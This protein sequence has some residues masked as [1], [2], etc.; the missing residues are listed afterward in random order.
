MPKA[1]L[2]ET[3]EADSPHVVALRSTL[4]AVLISPHWSEPVTK[5]GLDGAKYDL[6]RAEQILDRVEQSPAVRAVGASVLN[7]LEAKMV[8]DTM[9]NF[10]GD[11]EAKF[12]DG[13]PSEER[14]RAK[15]IRVRRK[16]TRL[17][18]CLVALHATRLSVSVD[19]AA[20]HLPAPGPDRS[21]AEAGL[22]DIDGRRRW[23]GQ[24]QRC[25]ADS[26]DFAA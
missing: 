4:S 23:N 10:M 3:V 12:V 9:D 5:Q 11:L 24:R 26:A 21:A 7:D 17:V 8:A 1:A 18:P 20:A 22:L 25:N 2:D 15:A 16:C 13:R 19:F 14:P 6:E